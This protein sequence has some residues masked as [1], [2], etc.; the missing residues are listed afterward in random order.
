VLDNHYIIPFKVDRNSRLDSSLTVNEDTFKEKIDICTLWC[1][2]EECSHEKWV[3][4]L[5]CTI[6]KTF[7]QENCFISQL[8]P[9]CSAKVSMIQ[10]HT[11]VC[12]SVCLYSNI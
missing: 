11:T 3:T 6:L 8:V 5:V 9:V 7:P 1:P 12:K 10:R 4:T 2:V